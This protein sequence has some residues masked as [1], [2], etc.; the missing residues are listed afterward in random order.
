[1][2]RLDRL[3]REYVVQEQLLIYLA[4]KGIVLLNASSGENITEAINSDPMKKANDPFS[5]PVY[6]SLT[7]C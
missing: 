3:A 5:F 7:S 6:A 4:S 1:V 2:E